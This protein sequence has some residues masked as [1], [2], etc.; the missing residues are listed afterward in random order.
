MKAW[1]TRL[2]K[3]REIF[4]LALFALLAALIGFCLRDVAYDDTYITYRYARNVIQG[5]GFVYNEGERVLSTTA[6]LYAFLLAAVGLLWSDLPRL[7]NFISALSL[8]GAGSFLYLTGERFGRGWAGAIAGALFMLCP[9]SLTTIGFETPFYLMLLCGAFYFYHARKVSMA[10]IL[11]AFALLT[12]ADGAV[13]ALVI[14]GH[15]LL[16]KRRVPWRELA[17]YM[18][19]AAPFLIYLTFTFGSPFPATL[20]AKVL[21]MRMGITGFYPGST[22]L[23]GARILAEAFFRQ[24]FLYL[25]FFLSIP[26]GLLSSVKGES[27][28]VILWVWAGLHAIAYQLLS[29]APYHWYYA[30][31]IPALSTASGLGIVRGGQWLSARGFGSRYGIALAAVLSACIIAA[32]GLSDWGIYRV[33]S[34]A[35]APDPEEKIYKILP[36]VKT[37]VYRRVGQW[38]GAHT[39]PQATVGV[40]EVGVIGYYSERKIIDFLGLIEPEVAEALSYWNIYWAIPHYQPDYIVLTEVNPLYSYYM[41]NDKWFKSVYCPVQEFVDLRFWAGPITVYQRQGPPLPMEEHEVDVDLGGLVR[42][43]GYRIDRPLVR[44]GDPVRIS[45]LWQPLKT[46]SQEYSGFVHIVDADERIVEGED[47][48]YATKSWPKGGIVE[49]YH[50]IKFPQTIPLGRYGIKVG[51]YIPGDEP[52][53]AGQRLVV[54]ETGQDAA[55]IGSIEVF[56]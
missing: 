30:P 48:T 35:V 26:L 37:S 17:L 1:T 43:V 2:V 29:V 12:R 8:F 44:P 55:L 31:L 4:V 45:L 28:A 24:S 27:W 42:L 39:P 22:F 15:Y 51:M 18:V 34:G 5:K 54:T 7:S 19:I 21:Q 36:E 56:H 23:D 46:L 50:N 47:D 25:L 38:L 3:R 9:L 6:P 33:A 13:P 53:S 16:V 49:Y 20:R 32:E 52:Q 40:M 14:F 41:G 10:A 11:L